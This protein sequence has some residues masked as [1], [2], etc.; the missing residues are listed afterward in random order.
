MATR[1]RRAIPL[2]PRHPLAGLPFG[3]LA[4]HR[5]GPGSEVIG[6]RAYRPGDPVSTID[7]RATARVSSASGRDEFV[8]RERR[9]EDAPRVVLVLDRRPAMELYPSGLPWLRK[10]DAVREVVGLLVESAAAA[11]AE[12]AELDYADGTPHWLPPSTKDPSDEL[13]RRLSLPAAAPDGSLE[14]ALTE[15]GTHQTVLRS[16][17]FVFVVSDFLVPVS[18]T[19]WHRAS[20]RGWDVVPVV[21]QDP[22]WEAGFPEVW[23]AALPL[24]DPGSER[25]R[26]VRVSRREAA[27]R[28]RD[29]AER[30]ERTLETQ[31]NAGAEPFLVEA[32]DPTSIEAAFSRWADE[33][34]GR[35]WR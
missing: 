8:V 20:A 28:A 21:I 1:E 26:L 27:R 16:G 23:G 4:S 35:A 11:R 32:D 25:V 31:R 34:T 29:N 13:S 24:G 17:T 7:W 18:A 9:A 5:R 15:L 12:L 10:G 2:V 33:R 3:S 22:I 30:L 6:T 19:A 14:R